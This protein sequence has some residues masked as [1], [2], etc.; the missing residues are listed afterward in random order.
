M[1]HDISRQLNYIQQVLSQNRKHLGFFI[2]AGCPL[3]IRIKAEGGGNKPL[4]PDVAGLTSIINDKMNS[5][6]YSNS[7]DKVLK[8]FKDDKIENPNIEDILSHIRAL[9]EVAGSGEVR[10]LKKD[11]L[12]SLDQEICKIIAEEVNKELPTESSPYHDLAVWARSISRSVPIHIFSTNYDLLMEQALEESHCP[13]FDGFIGT[14]KAFFDLG[15]LENE[16]ELHAKWCRLWK[17][18]GSINWTYTK[19][20]SIVRTYEIKEGEKYLIYPSHL[21]YKKSRKMPYLAMIDRLKAFILS[22]S[23]VLF[24]CGYSFCD[25]HINDMILRSLQSNPTAMCFALLFDRLENYTE[26]IDCAKQTTNISLLAVD[27]AI[28]GRREGEYFLANDQ[29]PHNTPVGV[30]EK[31]EGDEE[32]PTYRFKIGDFTNFG[33]ILKS[34]SGIPSN[35]NQDNE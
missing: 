35:E 27:K 25:E 1:K 20:G 12:E 5:G 23:S 13:Y 31:D 3:A 2:G 11:I 26:A 24:I 33:G 10:G 15:T 34:L 28:I 18:H 19:D 16:H 14:K 22:P 8:H 17:I 4:I 6:D 21:K 32:P 30:I 9:C 29:E 7:Y